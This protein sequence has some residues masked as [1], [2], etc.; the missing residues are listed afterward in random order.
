[1]DNI[2]EIYLC[3]ECN[4]K[5]STKGGKNMHRNLGHQVKLLTIL[6]AEIAIRPVF[7]ERTKHLDAESLRLGL[8]LAE[9]I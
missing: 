3:I 6:P 8:S 1:M 4:K 2:P 7:T 5:L 9:F